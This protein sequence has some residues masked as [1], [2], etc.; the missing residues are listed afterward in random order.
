MF[1]G[2]RGLNKTKIG[3]VFLYIKDKKQKK[4]AIGKK[5]DLKKIRGE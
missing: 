2:K 1:S 5:S 4:Y 3:L